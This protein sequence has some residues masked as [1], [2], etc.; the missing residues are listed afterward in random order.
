MLIRG[1]VPWVVPALLA[2]ALK[3]KETW[4]GRYGWPTFLLLLLVGAGLVTD[5]QN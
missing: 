3:R 2:L 1:F 4:L 5:L